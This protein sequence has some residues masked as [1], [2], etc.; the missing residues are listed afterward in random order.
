MVCRIFPRNFFVV[1][2]L[3]F[4]LFSSVFRLFGS[5]LFL[6]LSNR[7]K[8]FRIFAN[9]NQISVTSNIIKVTMKKN[10]EPVRIRYK[11]L[12][13]GTKSIYLDVYK[14]GKRSYEF[15]KLYLLP[16][17]DNATKMANRETLAKAE[18]IK[19]QRV[20]DI[21]N[22]VLEKV[23]TALAHPINT[24]KASKTSKK[25]KVGKKEKVR[26]KPEALPADL[27]REGSKW[28]FSG[29]EDAQQADESSTKQGRTKKQEPVTLRMKALSNGGSSLYLDIYNNG[30]R[31]YEFLKLYLNPEVTE[32]DK[33][34]NA[35]VMEIAE[36]I[37]ERRIRELNG[38][39]FDDNPIE[40]KPIEGTC[41]V[42]VRSRKMRN[43][44]RSLFLDIYGTGLRAYESLGLYL[45]RTDSEE[46]QKEIWKEAEKQAKA[47]H[48]ALRNGTFKKRVKRLAYK[49][50]AGKDE[51]VDKYKEYL[52]TK[53]VKAE[54]A[55]AE[56]ER[57]RTAKT[58]EPVRVRFKDL[59]NGNK[60][61]YLA[62]N[63]NGH[64][65]Y[66]YLK[67]Y[68]IPEIDAAAKE[69]NKQTMQAVY[70]IK[71]QR[72]MSI[73]NGI[74]GLKD[75]SRIKMRLVDWLEIFR[76]AQVQRGRVSARNWVNA[77][78][79]SVRQYAQNTTLAEID[80]EWCNGFMVFLLNEYVTYKNSHPSKSTVM[81][82][83]KCLKAAFNMAIEE[84]IL[85]SN[86]VLRL[87]MDVLKGGGNKREYLTVDEVKKLI[88]TPCAR[89]DVKKAF[90]FSCFCG[91]RISDVKSLKWKNVV[92]EG[93]KTRVEIL[94]YKTKQ[95]LYLPLNKQALRWMPERGNAN[96][97]DRVFPTLPDKNYE[98]V[99]QWARDAGISKHVTYHVSRHTFATMEL[100]MGADLY[101]TSKLMGHTEVRTTEIYAKI[102]NQKK[103][104]AVSL[105][106]SAFDD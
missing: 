71:A 57:K 59:A 6:I 35:T 52:V 21:S 19:N 96:D 39:R 44:D 67:L 25:D 98:C 31:T 86:P 89:E 70:A 93:D 43:G 49:P 29:S 16:E 3:L 55:T 30:E 102:V 74:A 103:D 24:K 18:E 32:A 38:E 33:Q 92:T 75:K 83:L 54:I 15:L 56:A 23:K 4:H 65:T 45:R 77:V 37:K 78:L 9:E 73:T 7:T 61:V 11:D 97:E 106:D 46:V 13:N 81:N 36:R 69:Q 10:K 90:L 58:K 51:E 20:Q 91:L 28:K 53:K 22:G 104:E 105:L 17:T 79:N 8:F 66:D 99:P 88:D 101:T 82:Y 27:G 72:I 94:Q 1:F 63:V 87:R 12:T 14:D 47:C 100:T 95:P 50:N 68:L 40:N 26:K 64:R 84:E 42:V 5:Y 85:D 60:S 48:D 80:K 2:L 34:N 41:T 62:I 76:D